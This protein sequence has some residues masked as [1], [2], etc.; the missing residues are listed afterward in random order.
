MHREDIRVA[1]DEVAFPLFGDGTLRPIEAVEL[2]ALR[3]DEAFGRVDV[4]GGLARLAHHTP[5][6]GDEATAK[7]THGEDDTT[8]EAVDGLAWMVFVFYG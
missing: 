5:P 8:A 4:L 6:E 7:V 2:T 3:V 1:F